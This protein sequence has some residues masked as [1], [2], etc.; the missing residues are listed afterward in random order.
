MM[1]LIEK[2]QKRKCR[3]EGAG[4]FATVGLEEVTWERQA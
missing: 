1:D 2:R 4:E 3:N